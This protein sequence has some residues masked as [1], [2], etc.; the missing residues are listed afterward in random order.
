MGQSGVTIKKIQLSCLKTKIVFNLL[1]E[2][3]KSKLSFEGPN[4]GQY[5]DGRVLSIKAR[6][7]KD[8]LI[9]KQMVE[10]ICGSENVKNL[11]DSP[12]DQKVFAIHEASPENRY[13]DE[14]SVTHIHQNAHA[15]TTLEGETFCP[16]LICG[17]IDR[18]EEAKNALQRLLTCF[19]PKPQKEAFEIRIPVNQNDAVSEEYFLTSNEISEGIPTIQPS[20]VPNPVRKNIPT[21]V[22]TSPVNQRAMV[23]V[24]AAKIQRN[25][26]PVQE[27]PVSAKNTPSP[28]SE[29][30]VTVFN[31]P[32][33]IRK[34]SVTVLSTLSS[35]QNVSTAITISSIPVK[36]VVDPAA[37]GIQENLSVIQ[38][39]VSSIHSPPASLIIATPVTE[40]AGLTTCTKSPL[41]RQVCFEGQHEEFE[42]EVFNEQ[43]GYFKK[44]CLLVEKQMEQI[45]LNNYEKKTQLGIPASLSIQ[46][47]GQTIQ[48]QNQFEI[49]DDGLE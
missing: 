27:V 42:I 4:N 38:R 41:K 30:P 10:E 5:L 15:C 14:L 32:S 26:S 46:F 8:A 34:K 17:P 37:K 20:E 2:R 48:L 18:V 11:E 3:S 47:N 49:D 12:I 31:T 28:V 21:P 43:Q 22:K 9:A 25:P 39:S 40:S 29:V 1:Q 19:V 33:P 16:V 6:S 45:E 24:A 13:S 36:D 23:P 7:E 44:R 35:V